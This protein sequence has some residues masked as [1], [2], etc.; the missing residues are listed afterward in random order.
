MRY[1]FTSAGMTNSKKTITSIFEDIEKLESSSTADGD[2]EWGSPLDNSWAV[3]QERKHRGTI[4]PSNF[5][6]R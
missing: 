2:V 3:P 5:V 1:H 6:S 4:V